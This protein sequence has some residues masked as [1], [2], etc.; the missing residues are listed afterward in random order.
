MAKTANRISA[1]R[2]AVRSAPKSPL[3]KAAAVE[4]CWPQ[5]AELFDAARRLDKP[6]FVYFIGEGGDAGPVKIGLSREPIGRLRQMQTGNSRPL[7]IE[8]VLVGER[9]LEK[10]LHEAWER[11]AIASPRR[12]G[13]VQAAPGTEWFEPEIRGGLF[14]VAELAASRQAGLLTAGDVE[15]VALGQ[16]VVDAHAEKGF[17]VVGREEVRRLRQ[18]SGYTGSRASRLR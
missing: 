18:G 9:V 11:F 7:R 8:Y 15:L 6:E 5:V 3:D 16:A 1:G 17:S 2:R 13:K 12:Q 10:L 14:P 4:V